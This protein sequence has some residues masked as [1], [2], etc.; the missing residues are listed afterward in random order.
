MDA[1]EE[2]KSRLSIEDV[3]SEYVQLKRAGRNFRGTSPF[4]SEKTPSFMVSPEKQIWHDFSS[5]KGGN[6][7]SFIMEVEGLDFKGALELLARKA[8]IDL[9]QFRTSSS[10]DHK[11]KDQLLDVLKLSAKFYQTQFSKNQQALEYIFKKR[12]FTKDIVLKFQLGYSPNNGSALTNF[13]KKKSF[14]DQVLKQAGLTVQRYRG[15]GD[16]FIGRLMIPLMDVQGNVIG[17]T[18][19]YLDDDPNVP[20]YINTPQTPLYD[21]SRHVYGLHLAKEAI[22]K[23]GYAVIVEGNLDVIASHQI[24]FTEVVATAGTAL[25]EMHLKTLSRFTHD[26]RLCFDQDSAGQTAAE[27]AIPIAAKVGVNLSILTIKGAKDPDELIKKTPDSWKATIEKPQYVIDWLIERYRNQLDLN[28][29]QGKRQFTDVLLTVIRQLP[30]SVEQ[31][32]YLD[33]ISAIIGTS[34]EALQSKL[35]GLGAKPSPNLRKIKAQ[36]SIDTTDLEQTKTQNQ[37]L[38]IMLFRVN[39]RK[40]LHN[41]TSEMLVG[42]GA[43]TIVD[44]LLKNP[45]YAGNLLSEPALRKVADYVKILG[46]QYEALY[47]DLDELEAHY[48]ANRLQIRLIDH[49]VK[50]KKIALAQTMRES[51]EKTID[52][53]LAEAKKL[54][55]LLKYTKG[56]NNG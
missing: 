52:S 6:I 10:P 36:L 54:D 4:T 38:A 48:E 25:T 24:G 26:I 41:I 30:D 37:L 51:D 29:V 19:R 34:R 5:G 43:I 14:S 3:I 17:F 47:Q 7:F 22:R 13:L 23:K 2:I 27:R 56:V 35:T 16:M 11:M 8:S 45:N 50:T 12:Q 32:H 18:A 20:K 9:E 33:K 1:V 42:E 21:K 55:E 15:T 40:S 44:F 53:L 28:S 46:L 49:F 39:L 31:E